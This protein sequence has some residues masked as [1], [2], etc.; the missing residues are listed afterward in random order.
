[1]LDLLHYGVVMTDVSGRVVYINPSAEEV[2]GCA[3]EQVLGRPFVE[4]LIGA[5]YELRGDQSLKMRSMLDTQ[6]TVE[7]ESQGTHRRAV[8]IRVA[9]LSE[10]EDA[11][12][13]ELYEIRDVSESLQRTRQLIHEATHDPLTGLANRRALTERLKQIFQ[14]EPE[15]GAESVLAMLDLDGFKQINDECGHLA[16]DEVLRDI[17]H[18]LQAYTRKA[19]MTVRL[20]GDEFVLLLV[21]CGLHEAHHLMEIIR[22]AVDYYRFNLKGAEY[23]VTTSIGI[24]VLDAGITEV[25]HALHS[26]DKACYEA[27][28]AGGN[29]IR[30]TAKQAGHLEPELMPY[31]L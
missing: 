10:D 14:W 20:G 13:G 8:E 17:A 4:T 18:L 9:P 11:N 5:G 2:I 23:R 22:D 19:D 25:S 21:D 7:L 27:K 30:L 29:C 6:F 3:A 28:A 15:D 24:V 31:V 26:A 16:G 12:C 1:M